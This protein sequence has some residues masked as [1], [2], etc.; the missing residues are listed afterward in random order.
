MLLQNANQEDAANVEEGIIHLSVTVAQRNKSES[1]QSTEKGL[2]AMDESTTLH[3]SLVPKANVVNARIMFHSHAGSS[4][5]CT[6]LLTLLGIKLLKVEKEP[7][8]KCIVQ[9]SRNKRK[10]TL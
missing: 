4:Y 2:T 1:G 7:L 5:V 6:S 8:N 10:Y 3:A 9:S